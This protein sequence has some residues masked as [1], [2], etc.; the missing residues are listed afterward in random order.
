MVTLEKRSIK[1]TY[2]DHETL[3]AIPPSEI[4]TIDFP[5]C[6][7]CYAPLV[8]VETPGSFAIM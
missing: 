7:D 6:P 1:C 2:C 5:L 3:S 8:L 4:M